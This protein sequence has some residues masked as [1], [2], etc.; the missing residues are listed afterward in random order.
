MPHPQVLEL[1]DPR[2]ALRSSRVDSS[3]G[4][5]AEFPRARLLSS[6]LKRWLLRTHHGSVGS[7]HLQGYLDECTFRFNRRI[8]RR[9][10]K[11]FY[12]LAEQLISRQPIAY[13]TFI[14]RSDPS[15]SS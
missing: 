3:P 5:E 12:R 11:I 9:I 10:R 14:T 2:Y 1:G 7:K 8:S 6:L 4:L 13:K 15:S